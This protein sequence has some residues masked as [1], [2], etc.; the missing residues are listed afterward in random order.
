[1][2]L[3]LDPVNL[4]TSAFRLLCRTNKLEERKCAA[5]NKL[6]RVAK[7]SVRLAVKIT[8]A[9]KYCDEK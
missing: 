5:L 3:G 9:K 2:A 7:I 6:L 1:M 4:I 8:S